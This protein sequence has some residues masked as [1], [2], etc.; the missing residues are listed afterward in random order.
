MQLYLAPLEGVTGWIYRSAVHECFGGFDKYFIPFIKPNQKGH[1]SAREKKDIGVDNNKGM[2]AVPQILTNCAEDFVET[3]KRLEQYGY[4]EINLNVGC[5]S[6]TVVTK[7]RGSG[8]LATPDELDHFLESVFSNCPI[9]VS[10]KTRLGISEGEEFFRI[11]EIYNRYPMSELIVHPRTQKDFYKNTP[12]MDM[13]DYVSNHSKNVLC[14]N[15]DI[16]TKE[17]CQKFQGTYPNVDRIMIGRGTIADPSIARQCKGGKALDKKELRL[18]HDRLYEDY[19]REM[20]G[21]R[22]VLYKMKEVWF[23]LAP[24]FTNEKKYAKKIKKS[25]KCVVYDEIIESLFANEDLKNLDC[26]Q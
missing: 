16:R 14:Y 5:P 26:L 23:Y 8:F 20:S 2:Y 17:E 22:T 10:V 11:L 15:G 1:F 21:E 4:K 6:K 25:E 9:E 13:F 24:L 3:A 18:F 12:N 19:C 7:G